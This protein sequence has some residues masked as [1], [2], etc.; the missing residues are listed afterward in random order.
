MK[1]KPTKIIK[2]KPLVFRPVKKFS[3]RLDTD[4]DGVLDFKDC[5]PFNRRHQHLP[6][7]RKEEIDQLPIVVADEEY[8]T[9]EPVLHYDEP[10]FY[11][12][13]SDE[14][15]KRSP[16]TVEQVYS[17]FNRHP[18]L[19]PRVRKINEEWERRS[20]EEKI[21]LEY[22]FLNQERE[23]GKFL[24]VGGGTQKYSTRP[25]AHSSGGQ[26]EIM[27][28]PYDYDTDRI[29][30]I[31][32]VKDYPT[33]K[34]D[35]V[36]GVIHHELTHEEQSLR[37]PD[38]LKKYIAYNKKAHKTYDELKEELGREPTEEDY[39]K[40]L[41]KQRPLYSANPYEVEANKI[42]SE[43]V[44]KRVRKVPEEEVEESFGYF[45]ED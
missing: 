39:D 20:D 16:R 24:R 30:N 33:K 28:K 11:P 38:Y 18:E 21:P 9:N 44:Y 10:D 23:R 40:L 36:A 8:P 32:H 43:Q 5:M 3:F 27:D 19:I 12:L 17:T 29:K 13:S 1:I 14:A 15:R 31:I 22:S 26:V 2:V 34:Q 41:E 25:Y 4:R 35:V 45:M 42:A 37:D 6:K 7:R